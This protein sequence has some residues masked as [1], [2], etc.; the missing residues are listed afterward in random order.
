[1]AC[2]VGCG[3][4]CSGSI[5]N[6]C[7]GATGQ[8]GCQNACHNTCKN[9]C[10]GGCTGCAGCT[11][12]CASNCTGSCAGG[13]TGCGTSCSGS[14]AGGCYSTDTIFIRA[15]QFNDIY[16]AHGWASRRDVGMILSA[17]DDYNFTTE[18]NNASSGTK[19]VKKHASDMARWTVTLP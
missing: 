16:I 19:I 4:S 1:M 8:G 2:N 13:C 15:M 12:T 10:T 7:A 17:A 11:S 3:K 18:T 6:Y 5:E 9:G 14:C